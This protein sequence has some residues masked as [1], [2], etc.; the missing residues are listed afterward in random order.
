VKPILITTEHRGVFF[1]YVPEDQ[2]MTARTMALKSARCAIYWATK[3]GVAELAAIGPNENSRIG[4]EADIEAIHDIT[5]VWAV[6]AEA[7]AAWKR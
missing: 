1:G 7:E 6:T 3:T 4:A 5:A 2:D